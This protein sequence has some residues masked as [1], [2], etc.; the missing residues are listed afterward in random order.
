M[1]IYCHGLYVGALAQEIYFED[2]SE[3]LQTELH[4]WSLQVLDLLY[5]HQVKLMEAIYDPVGLTHD[6]KIFVRY[7][8]N[9]ALLNLGFEPYFEEEEVNPVVLNGLNTSTGTMD[10]FS[11]KGTGY[12]SMISEMLTDSDFANL[13]SVENIAVG[14]PKVV[15]LGDSEEE[16]IQWLKESLDLADIFSASR[17]KETEQTLVEYLVKTLYRYHN[18]SL[19]SDNI[20]DFLELD[21]NEKTEVLFS[22]FGSEESDSEINAENI[23]M[24]TWLV[25]Y[26]DLDGKKRDLISEDLETS[27]ERLLDDYEAT[28]SY[29]RLLKTILAQTK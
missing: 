8:A 17:L 15:T 19:F 1:K 3:E 23:K 5:S 6:V 13:L 4:T 18:G 7:N 20:L 14:S 2:F 16:I 26:F 11:M 29:R 24:V 22:V 28:Y 27:N 25:S 12:Q 9:K 21:E 10:F